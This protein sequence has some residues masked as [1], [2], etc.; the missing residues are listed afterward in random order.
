M[1]FIILYQ[2]NN[3]YI[4][5]IITDQL[6]PLHNIGKTN[7]Q[8]FSQIYTYLHGIKITMVESFLEIFLSDVLS[9]SNN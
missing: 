3:F 2:L 7:K 4:I 1:V 9:F 5:F 6:K 8:T